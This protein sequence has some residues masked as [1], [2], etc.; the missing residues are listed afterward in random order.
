MQ[1]GLISDTHIP[2]RG[3]YLPPRVFEIFADVD[4]IIHAGDLME[5]TVLHE[6]SVIAPVYAVAGNTDGWDVRSK[7]P[8]RRT[9][10]F[11]GYRI[12][13]IHGDGYGGDTPTRALQAFSEVDCVVFGHSHIPLNEVR[14]GVLLVNPGSPTDPRGLHPTVGLLHIEPSGLRAEIIE[15]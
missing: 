6:L 4:L 13:V 7:L 9:L 1:I 12:G 3:R 10:E 5:L 11:D 15:L 8:R 14:Q 2:R